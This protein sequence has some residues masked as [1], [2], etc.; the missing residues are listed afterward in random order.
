MAVHS[1][2][3]LVGNINRIGGVLVHKSIPLRP[4]SEIN[5]DAVARQ[6][7][8]RPRLDH[9]GSLRHPFTRSL[10]N[11]LTD[12]ILKGN[13]SPVDTLL[14]FSANPVYTLPDGGGF[15]KALEKVPFIVSFS[16]FR[17]E[18]SL[19]ADI[20]VPDHM[21][22]EKMDDIVWPA[23]LQYPLYGVSQP[24]VESLYDTRNAGDT[25]LQLAARI[26]GSVGSAF[27]W[28]DFEAVLR[29]RAKGLFYSRG[30]L[31]NYDE[32]MPAWRQLKT[33]GIVRRDY[34]SFEDMWEKIKSGGLWYRPALTTNNLKGLFQTPTGK[35]EFFSTQIELAV[36]DNS[37][38]TSEDTALGEMGIREK[39]DVVFMPHY[40]AMMTDVDGS[41]Y[42]LLMI[43]YEM[44]NLSSG[45]LP[46]PPFLN[47][48]LFDNQLRKDE[49]F[50]EINPETAAEYDLKQG[51]RVIVKSPKGEIQVRVNLFEGAMPGIVYLPLGLGHTA[52]DEFLKG[53]GA[54][55]NDIIQAGK[56]PLAGHPIW[57]RTPVKLIKV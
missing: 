40:E 57:W 34:E 48:S 23:G 1:L 30:G 32:S 51:C 21:S 2:N 55:P 52:Y 15:K 10:I 43:P 56:D 12:A 5:A 16:P 9:A 24:V 35:F 37:R 19:L 29:A 13:P 7:L 14:V 49:S 17:D 25:I 11:N 6:G 53:K 28:E 3:A 41:D 8:K 4:L 47:K 39:G 31:T 22:L 26:G 44:I 33:G 46:N 38:N 18:T 36:Y 50:A 27:P 42:P 45:W 20:I 54:N